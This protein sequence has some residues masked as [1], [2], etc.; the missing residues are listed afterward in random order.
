MMPAQDGI[1]PSSTSLAWY[2]HSRTKR[3]GLIPC[4]WQS[5]RSKRQRR[6]DS[7]SASASP[8]P[9][10]RRTALRVG[11]HDI[12]RRYYEKAFDNFQQLNCRMIAKAWIKLVE[13]RKQVNHPYN[14]RKNVGGTSQRVDPELTKPRWWPTGVTHKEPDH[15]PKPGESNPNWKEGIFANIYF[16]NRTSPSSYPHPLRI[17]EQPRYHRREAQR[18]WSRCATPNLAF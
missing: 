9:T 7:D 12:L 11:D 18:G 14:G 16:H 10:I 17:E 13:P 8:C 2:H 5:Q 1:I 6:R 4:E 3:D 15:L